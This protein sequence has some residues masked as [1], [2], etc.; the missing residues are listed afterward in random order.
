MAPNFS[1]RR[2]QQ[3]MKQNKLFAYEAT[4][5]FYLQEPD[6]STLKAR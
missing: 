6:V 4:R 1:V 3:P 2:Q 5:L